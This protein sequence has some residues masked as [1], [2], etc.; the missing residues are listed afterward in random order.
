MKFNWKTIALSSLAIAGLQF[1]ALAQPGLEMESVSIFKN[2]T[3]FFVKSGEVKTKNK[4]YEVIGD[5]IPQALNGTFWLSS[6]TNSID[7]VK[8]YLQDKEVEGLVGSYA[9]MLKAN[10]GK[11]IRLLKAGDSTYIEGKVKVV[12]M[13]NPDPSKPDIKSNT[14]FAITQKDGKTIMLTNNQVNG[15]RSMEFVDA[16]AFTSTS[17]QK[18][19]VMQVNFNEAKA[20]QPLHMMYLSNGLSWKPDYLVELLD[21][22][23]ARLSLRTTVVNNAEDI[24]VGKLNLVAGVPNFKYATSLSDFLNLLGTRPANN[25]AQPRI[26]PNFSNAAVYSY[27]MP[28]ADFGGGAPAPSP[29]RAPAEG[30]SI[31][32]LFYYTLKDVE[33]KKGERALLDVFNTEVKIKH[34]YEVI[35]GQNSASYSTAYSYEQNKLPVV[36]TIKLFNK[37]DYVWTSAAVMVVKNDKGKISPVSQDLLKYTSINDDINVKLTEAPDVSVKF[38]EKEIKREANK[39]QVRQSNN[40]ILYYDLVTVESEIDIQNFKNKDIRIDVKRAIIGELLESSEKWQKA[41]RLQNY[42]SYNPYTDVCWEMDIKKGEE[43]KVTFTYQ[44]YVSHY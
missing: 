17:V 18:L 13:K 25:Y 15:A 2:Q 32:D 22:E 35:L 9:D 11:R 37:S 10:D 19:P 28:E 4:Q 21:D 36:H 12:Q 39:K 7:I 3:A 24:K 41:P 20:K 6:P 8:S 14:L 44:I 30:T 1:S 33:L 16:P 5:T 23:K 42:N 27:D 43:K 40:R 31:E 38:T 34:V 26:Q 29:T